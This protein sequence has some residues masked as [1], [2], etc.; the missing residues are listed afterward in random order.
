VPEAPLRA[1][2]ELAWNRQLNRWWHHYNTEY[3]DEVLLVPQID[4]SRGEQALGRWDLHRRRLSVSLHH[5]E[6]DPWSEVLETLRHEMAHQYA[7]EV[8]GAG[9]EKPHGPAFR[10][11]CQRLRCRPQ[12]VWHREG[13]G[14][15]AEESAV[16]RRLKKVLSLAASPNENEAQV[17]MRKARRLLLEYNIDA[18]E[19][20]HQRQFSYRVLGQVKGRRAA[21][22]LWLAQILH[23]FFFVEVL[24][25]PSYEAATDRSGTVLHIYGTEA[26]LDMADY[27]YAYL[28]TL[29]ENLWQGYRD[30]QGLAGN[31]QRLPYKGGV[32]EGLHA[33]LENQASQVATGTDLVWKGDPLL[34]RYYSYLHPRVRTRRSG[35]GQGGAAYEAGVR[36]GHKVSIHRPLEGTAD[37]VVPLLE[38]R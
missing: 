19:F 34:N 18:V 32:L 26:N 13:G 36:Q 24:W 33:R 1:Q 8:L 38:T 31:R 23:R 30:L 7:D 35:G 15:A 14:G 11:A 4:L 25:A 5:I 28:N 10:R 20:D 17:A 37:G 22:E 12:A 29:L 3:L 16:M 6:T 27:I 21:Y 2:L 9:C